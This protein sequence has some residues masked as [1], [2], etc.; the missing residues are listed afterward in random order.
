MDIAKKVGEFSL[1]GLFLRE[2]NPSKFD[3]VASAPWL[4]AQKKESIQFIARALRSRLEP[5][6]LLSLSRIVLVEKGNRGLEAIRKAIA[7]RHGLAEVG[8]CVFFGVPIKHAYIIT[9]QKE[10]SA[11]RVKGK[12]K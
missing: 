11:K 8:N 10:S 7:V 4:D 6:E 1:F 12:T 9:S 3:L 2:E 5:D